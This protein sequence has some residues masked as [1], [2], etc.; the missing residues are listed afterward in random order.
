MTQIVCEHC[1]KGGAG[2]PLL[3][4][5]KGRYRHKQCLPSALGD[6]MDVQLPQH[7]RS[8]LYVAQSRLPSLEDMR[9]KRT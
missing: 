1:G 5:E 6:V 9:G 4:V 7:V 2:G 8:K 3:K